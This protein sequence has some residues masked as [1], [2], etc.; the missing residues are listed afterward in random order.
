[1]KTLN[2]KSIT[3]DAIVNA[4]IEN[5]WHYWTE[6]EHI[7]Q[8]NNASADW[9]TPKATNDLRVGEKFLS[10]MEAKDGSFGF[11]F[12]GIY[13]KIIPNKAIHYVLED[14]RRVAIK[15]ESKG[16]TTEIQETFDAENVNSLELQRQGWQAILDN[17]KSYVENRIP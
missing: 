10:R 12:T 3:V 17:F 2:K 16:G 9:H 6:P 7:I 11:D 5:V 13:T 4:P 15:F 14:D 1:M 8:W